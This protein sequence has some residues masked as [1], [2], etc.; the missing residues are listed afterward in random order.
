MKNKKYREL[1]NLNKEK[2][3]NSNFNLVNNYLDLLR[4]G[5]FEIMRDVQSLKFDSILENNE[6]L[7][8]KYFDKIINFFEIIDEIDKLIFDLISS[9]YDDAKKNKEQEQEKNNI[10]NE[11]KNN[12]EKTSD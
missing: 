11:S 9:I 7:K 1:F 2:D 12:D 3:F 6:K 10:E 8:T 5:N 4:F